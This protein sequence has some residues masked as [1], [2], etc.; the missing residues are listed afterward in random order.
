MTPQIKQR[1]EQIKNN[2]IPEGYKSTQVGVVPCE[3]EEKRL[4]EITTKIGSGKTPLGGESVYKESGIPFIRSQNV[5]SGNFTFENLAFIDEETNKSMKSSITMKD[6]I[7]FNITGASIGRCCIIPNELVPSNLNQHVCIIRCKEQNSY[8]IS[9]QLNNELG[10][11]YVDSFQCGGGRQGLNF[12]QLG[13]FSFTLPNLSEQNR[14]AEILSTQDRVIEQQEKLIS[15]KEAQKKY[16]MQVLLTGKKRLKGFSGDWEVDKLGKYVFIK[17]GIAP[18]ELKLKE[19]GNYPYVKV[20]DMNNCLMYQNN[21]RFFTDTSCKQKIKKD[22]VIFPKRGA[23]IM[24]NKIRIAEREMYID[25]NMMALEVG[26]SLSSTYLYHC[27]SYTALYKIADTSTIPQINNVHIN[28]YLIP[29]PPLPEQEAIAEILSIADK[30][31]ELLKKQLK[32]EKLKK[33]SLMQLLLTG[34][35]RV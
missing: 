21:S 33:K 20:E 19:I 25:T 23:A 4:S 1:I 31:I 10:Q 28:P 3:W 7:L 27:L 18:A 8:Y 5:L 35:V 6:D 29:V 32:E 34:I 15:Q 30:E 11:K 9:L 2:E 24:L 12:Q 17:S 16:L 26:S 13:S 14:I 22:A